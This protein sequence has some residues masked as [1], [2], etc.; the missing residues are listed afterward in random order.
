MADDGRRN[1]TG[2]PGVYGEARPLPKCEAIARS[3]LGLMRPG[4]IDA[5]YCRRY[6]RYEWNGRRLCRVHFQ[7]AYPMLESMHNPRH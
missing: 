3:R 5:Y 1:G 4:N 2:T 7:A 6:A